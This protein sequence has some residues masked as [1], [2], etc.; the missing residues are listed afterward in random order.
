MMI[1]NNWKNICEKIEFFYKNRQLAVYSINKKQ[2]CIDIG[3]YDSV[4][5]N[6]KNERYYNKTHI[7]VTSISTAKMESKTL[8]RIRNELEK[9]GIEEGTIYEIELNK[10]IYNIGDVIIYDK[11]N[12]GKI[13]DIDSKEK[14]YPYA[15]VF[16][17]IIEDSIMWCAID[18]I[19]F[20]TDKQMI[21]K[22]ND[23]YLKNRDKIFEKDEMEELE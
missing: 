1:E 7:W 21:E 4:Q 14:N 9:Q 23:W 18:E 10:P 16:L 8:D 13:I 22:V 12:Y 20:A 17:D 19:S 6:D 15:V 5:R 3:L 11:T 2:K